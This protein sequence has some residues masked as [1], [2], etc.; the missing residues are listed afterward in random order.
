[1]K[2]ATFEYRV[3]DV[4]TRCALEGNSLAVFPE[5]SRLDD[6]TM[7]GIARELNLAET[8]F[9][10]PP[11]LPGCAARLRIFTPAREIPF[12][13]HPTLGTAFVLLES[14]RLP[15]RSG[16]FRLEE[17]IGPVDIEIG[18]ETPPLIW[19]R[20]PPISDGPSFARERC[21]SALGLRVAELLDVEPR[22]H[23]AGNPLVFVALRDCDAVDRAWLDVA[24]LRSLLGGEADPCCVYVFAQNPGGVYA[25]M[26]APQYGISEDPATGS[27]MGP[28]AAYMMRNGLLPPSGGTDFVCEQGTRMG[29]RSLLH[30]RIRGELGAE[31]IFAGGHVT[32]V[33]RA[34]MVLELP[35]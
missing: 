12:A 26:F 6:A 29:R 34:T 27:A 17:R 24:G 15:A 18:P 23:S 10:L 33:A 5:A 28:L 3:V 9:V 1:M 20:M 35:G 22:L 30:V 21:A 14:G 13:G 31:G 11:T 25:R 19:L 7:Q 16:K 8:T 4:F 2:P 32:P